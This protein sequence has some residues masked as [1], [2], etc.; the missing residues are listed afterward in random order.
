MYEEK[1]YNF[2]I[3][4]EVRNITI[5][6]PKLINVQNLEREN[7]YS[8]H[9]QNE[10]LF[11]DDGPYFDSLEHLIEH[12]RTM[13]DGL[14][15]ELLYPVPPNPRPPVPEMPPSIFTV[16]IKNKNKKKPFFLV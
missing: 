3:H 14:P 5:Y 12:Y 15:G 9:L 8:F 4:K 16:S 10:Y 13:P 7:L 11:I 1:A 2:L 6:K